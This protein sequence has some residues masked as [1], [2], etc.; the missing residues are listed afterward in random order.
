MTWEIFVGIGALLSFVIAV[1]GPIL[2]LNTSITKL[3][4]SVDILKSAIDRIEEDN[5]KNH[6]S[7]WEHNEEQDK[8]IAEHTRKINNI[9]HTMIMTERLHPELLGLHTQLNQE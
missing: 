1:T 5:E 8:T 4:A 2:K 9:E 3:N 6:K 7:L